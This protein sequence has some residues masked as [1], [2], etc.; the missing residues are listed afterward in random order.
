MSISALYITPTGLFST[1][2]A[3]PNPLVEGGIGSPTRAK[4]RPAAA[5]ASKIET[6]M[7]KRGI[8]SHE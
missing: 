7:F 4:A 2:A 6:R 5:A 3:G 8:S 1:I